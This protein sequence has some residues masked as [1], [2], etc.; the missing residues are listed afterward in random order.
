[1]KV[2]R[3]YRLAAAALVAGPLIFLF[4]SCS[5]SDG[6]FGLDTRRGEYTSST[7]AR[8]VTPEPDPRRVFIMYSAGFNSLSGY[9]SQ[10]LSDLAAGWL[11]SGKRIDGTLLVVSR[12]P[13]GY[14]DYATPT[15]PVL[16]RMY[17]DGNGSPVRD[18]VMVW[19]SSMN[20]CEGSSMREILTYIQENFPS[21]NYG[22]VFSS[23]ASGWLPPG[24]YNDPTAFEGASA[25]SPTQPTR[26][27]PGYAPAAEY[28]PPIDPFPAVK[29]I[30]QDIVGP[31]DDRRSYEMTAREFARAI[32]FHMDYILFDACLMGC[33]EVAYELKDV[34]DYVGFSQAEVLAEGFDYLNLADRLLGGDS[35]DPLAV[36][37]DYFAQYENAGSSESFA[38]ISLVETSQMEQLSRVCATL[39]DR[40]NG[41]LATMSG[42]GVQGYFRFGRHFFYDLEDI[43]IHAGATDDELATL[44][45]AMD[46]AIVY[47]AATDK[48][49]SFDINVFSGLSMYLPSMGTDYLDDFYRS[50]VSW[51]DATAL[52]R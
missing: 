12:H 5:S 27:A 40:Y 43:M 21:D 2:L 52:V 6:D 25:L 15:S 49:I 33:V 31:Q 37:K 30:G 10:D 47:K 16:Y 7:A 22:M 41:E 51:N 42:S 38:T 19:P 35:A 13:D 9:L 14:K 36:C 24:Y 3:L 26:R 50:E 48:F 28:Y 11:P 17:D 46:K 34:T 1:M 29:S 32:P 20:L 8:S 23:H 4:Q 18:T 44:R 39:F 45:A